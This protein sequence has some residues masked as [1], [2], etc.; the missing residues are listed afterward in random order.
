MEKTVLTKPFGEIKIDERQI[1]SFPDG[2]PGFDYIRYFVLLDSGDANSPFKWLQALD[3]ESLAFVIIQPSDF[4]DDYEPE[5]S[6]ADL[7][8]I[9]CVDE[10]KLLIFSIVTIPDD[11]AKMTANLQG[12]I[13]INTEKRIGRQSISMNERYSVRHR[14]LA[15]M[16]KT[17]GAGG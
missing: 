14:I 8:A 1:I 13:M 9:E 15:E 3:E 7:D 11:P 4:M 16:Q 17:S 12:P 5:I 10:Q 6:Q 2:I